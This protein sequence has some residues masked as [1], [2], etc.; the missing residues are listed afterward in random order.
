VAMPPV[1]I[2]LNFAQIVIPIGLAV[3]ALLAHTS[4]D[5]EAE[6]V[7]TYFWY[8][9]LVIW[10]VVVVAILVDRISGRA[11]DLVSIMAC[12]LAV[13]TTGL[14]VGPY[15]QLGDLLVNYHATR[16]VTPGDE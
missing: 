7:I 3:P 4:D 10:L 14:L 6:Q 8:L 16:L 5:W 12:I 11:T 15:C 1:D 2:I 13:I 9:P